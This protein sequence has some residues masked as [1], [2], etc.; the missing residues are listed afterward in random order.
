[1]VTAPSGGDI[2]LLRALSDRIEQDDAGAFNNLGVLYFSKGLLRD[3]VEAFLRALALEPRMRTAARNLEIAA[4]TPGACDHHLAALDAELARDIDNRKAARQRARMLRL[5][6]RHADAVQALDALIADDPDD[7]ASLFERGLLEQRVGDLR[8]AQRWFERAANAAADD[9]TARLHLAEVLYHRGQNEQSLD[10]LDALVVLAPRM[11]D[12]HLL[13]GFVLGDMGQHEA[14]VAAARLAASLNPSLETLQPNLSL[15]P[16]VPSDAT[17]AGPTRDVLGVEPLSGLARYGLG[18]AFRQRGYFAEARREFER[19]IDGGEDARLARH[20]IAELDL[21]AG[22]FDSA[23]TGYEAL[24]AENPDIA[25]HWNEHGVALHQ[26]GDL[27]GAANSYQRALRINPRYALAY[28]NLGVALADAD[29]GPAAREALVRAAELDASLISARLN[30]ARWHQRHRDPLAALATLREVVAFHPSN[31]EAWHEMGLALLG[32]RRPDDARDALVRAIEFRT[33]HAEA[34]YALAEV[35]GMLGDQEGA[36]RETQHALGLSPLRASSRLVVAIDLQVECPDA[37]ANV[38]LL[39]LRSG[40]PLQGVHVD[41]TS[42]FALLPETKPDVGPLPTPDDLYSAPCDEADRFASRG[43]HGE[44]LERYRETRLNS[45]ARGTNGADAAALNRRAAIG[46]ARSLC[47]LGHGEHA[48]DLLRAIGAKTPHD[49]EVLALFAYSAASACRLGTVAADTARSAMLRVLRLEVGGAALLHFVGDGAVLIHDDALALAFYRR[50]LSLD[51]TR[52]SARVAIA[53]LLRRRGDLLAA[54]LELV[55]ALAVNPEWRDAV[56]ELARVHRDAARP[57]DALHVL[58]RYLAKQP[59]EIAGLVLLSDVLIALDRDDDAR[60]AVS[61]V[62]RHE[63]NNAGALWFEGMLHQRRGHH[64][65][66][67]E[68]WKQAAAS[69]DGGDYAAR[70]QH[71]LVNPVV[72]DA[73]AEFAQQHVA[74][75]G[76]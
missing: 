51:P 32:L 41:A 74:G 6:G 40:I 9:P 22:A 56:L 37:L 38:D 49:P 2:E 52:P 55:A 65:D 67:I 50:A 62:R 10:V 46:E 39:S 17:F 45:E 68:R 33:D 23:R 19:A 75:V 15:D 8:R 73:E 11:A 4:A 60:V 54:R 35:L 26:C 29:E 36:L 61:R 59:T 12:A 34:R 71:A 5:I 18:L 16:V 48:F 76:A 13:R 20:A 58:T 53:T 47:L 72:P 24:L 28:N 1:M 66:A 31:A 42:V 30:V 63:P 7:A 64:R 43:L 57:L 70:A 44:A 21:V 25:R 3:A 27:R 69:D 14:G